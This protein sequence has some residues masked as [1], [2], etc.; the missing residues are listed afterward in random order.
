MVPIDPRVW[1][2]VLILLVVLMLVRRRFSLRKLSWLVLLVLGFHLSFFRDLPRQIPPGDFPV[3]PADG[4]V[5]EISS[6]YEDRYLH[7][8]AIKIGI[9]LSIFNSH[10][11]RCSIGGEVGYQHYEAGKFLN[12]LR[13]ESVNFNESNR[14]GIEQGGKR[15]LIRQISGAIAR[16]IYWDIEPGQRVERGQKLGII[17]YGSRVECFFPKR[18]FDPIIKIG[19]SVKAGTTIL[20]EWKS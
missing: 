17:C 13:K 20:G 10:V 4:K 14:I 15:V 8:E 6:V 12:A 3:S 11:N 16:R 19:Q 18:S 7:E 9:F 5:V 2:G 1:P